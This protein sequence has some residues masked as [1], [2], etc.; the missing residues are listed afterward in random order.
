MF[1]LAPLKIGD[2][3][4]RLFLLFSLLF[5][6]LTTPVTAQSAPQAVGI[7]VAA[8]SH[9][10][11]LWNNPNGSASL[12]NIDTSGTPVISPSYGSYTDGGG[13]WKPVAVSV[14]P[15]NLPRLLWRN[16]DGRSVFWYVNPNGAHGDYALP[17]FITGRGIPPWMPLCSASY[18]ACGLFGVEGLT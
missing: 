9:T 12:W 16:S 11:L 14:G 8:N 15:D 10:Y 1:V 2:H 5:C 6:N 3:D 17:H 7:A 13:T 18:G 4:A